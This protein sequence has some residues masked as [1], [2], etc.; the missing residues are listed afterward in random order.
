VNLEA[1]PGRRSGV[2]AVHGH[3]PRFPTTRQNGSLDG[4][5]VNGESA[6]LVAT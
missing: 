4:D 5:A 3:G 6:S 2:D 1:E